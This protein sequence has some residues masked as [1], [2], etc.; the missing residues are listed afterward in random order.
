MKDAI[1]A[2]ATCTLLGVLACGD[3]TSGNNGGATNEGAGGS[4][5]SNGGSNNIGAG[6]GGTEGGAPSSGGSG[7]EAPIDPCDTAL[8]CEKFDDYAGVTD[9]V[10]DQEFG[11]W[12]ASLNADGAVMNLDGTNTT[13]GSSALHIHID[14]AVE[15][16]GRLF[17]NGDHPLFE[18]APLE[19][20]G[21]MMMYSDPNGPSVHW[22]FF[23]ASGDADPGSPA[24]GRRATY[25]MSSLPREGVN[26]YSF[27]YGLAPEGDDPFH[28]CWF[29]SETPMPT[30]EWKCV[31]F[32]MNSVTRELRMNL[33][34]ASDPIASVDNTGQGCVGNVVPDDSSWFGPAVEEI[35]VGAWSFHPMEA[36]L[37]VWID[38]LVVDTSPV[39]CP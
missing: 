15:A 4:T 16:G 32:S 25:L 3:D 11:P 35:Y 8:F 21:R 28:D 13:S 20:Y 5:P 36:P 12:R 23:G 18:G 24:A 33:D 37:D 1:F 29:Q 22:T 38:D 27:V 2:F 6:V 39:P 26:T 30:A 9:I 14:G 17:A 7:G 10:D 34:G 31:E 19:L